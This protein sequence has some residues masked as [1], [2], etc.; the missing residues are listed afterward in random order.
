MGPDFYYE[1]REDYTLLSD[2]KILD[3]MDIKNIEKYLRKRKLKE[4][5]NESI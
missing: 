3:K 2:E 4:L 1:L 5:N